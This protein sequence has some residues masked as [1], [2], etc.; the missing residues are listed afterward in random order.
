MSCFSVVA[1]FHF[2]FA[3]AVFVE[4]HCFSADS[5]VAAS[6]DFGVA[7]VHSFAVAVVASFHSAFVEMHYSFAD[8]SVVASFHF[9]AVSVH[10]VVAAA[11][12][13]FGVVQMN[14]FAAEHCFAAV[15]VSSHSAGAQ[16]YSFF[17]PAVVKPVV[18]GPVSVFH[19]AC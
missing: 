12:S 13:D 19:F 1:A 16:D 17:A 9:D 11:S 3:V 7:P 18:A 2:V 14:F 5:S 6:F 15:V 4:L 10:S 8:S